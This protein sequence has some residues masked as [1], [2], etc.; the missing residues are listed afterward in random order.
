LATFARRVPHGVLIAMAGALLISMLTPLAALA[1]TDLVIGGTARIAYANGDPVAL[2]SAV[3]YDAEVLAWIPE[4][5]TVDVVDGPKAADDGALWYKV[6]ANGESG[7]IVSY[8]LA[9]GDGSSAPQ[10]TP[11]ESQ[12]SEPAPSDDAAAGAPGEITGIA[13]IAGTNN[14][15]VRCRS[16]ASTDGSV[17]TVLAEAT[18]VELIGDQTNGW[19]PVNCNGSAGFV[20]AEF[21]SASPP[22]EAPSGD[23]SD[24]SEAT[25][26]GGSEVTGSGTIYNTN[27][28]GIRCR[29]GASAEKNVIT[30]LTAG[31]KV[32]LRGTSATDWQPVFC[33]GRKGF[34]HKG[35]VQVGGSGPEDQ[36]SQ[37]SFSA[38]ATGTATVS[39]TNG[40]GVNCRASASYSGKVIGV[41]AEGTKVSLRGGVQG[42]WQPV[43]CKSRNGFVHKDYLRT[44]GASS[45]GS[46]SSGGSSSS[47]YT[48]VGTATVKTDD[49]SGLNCRAGAGFDKRIIT[50]LPN[51][52]KIDLRGRGNGD[53]TPVVCAGRKAYVVKM[54]VDFGG[55]TAG[56]NGSNSGNSGGS[57]SGLAAGDNAKV[58]G[59]NGT[60]VR[61]RSGASTT[62]S[63]ISVLVENTVVK[64]R[65]GS[66]GSWV[67]VTY[68]G[69]NGFVHK[70]YLAKT[71]QT[72]STPDGGSN[73]GNSGGGGGYRLANGDHAKVNSNLNLRYSPSFTGGV[74]AVAPA[75]T[76]VLITG[77]PK[78]G[79]YPVDWDGLKGYMYTDFLSKTSA[80]LSDRGGSGNN[81]SGNEDPPDTS[82]GGSTTIVNYAMQYLGYPYVWAT[83]GPGS[84]DCSGFTY[85]VIL[86]TVG[87]NIGAGLFTQVAAGTPVTRSSLQPGDLVFFQN[88]YTWGLS[89]VGIYIGN[90]QF[91]HAENAS[92]GVKISSLSSQY[93]SSRWYGAVRIR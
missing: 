51:G 66:T 9:L 6:R 44:G 32:D 76:V 13:Y 86:N 22:A 73:S 90:D 26:G 78:S 63:I 82:A 19:Q 84:F 38:A 3:G 47:G 15:G 81:N 52:S 34:I 93:Y 29:A 5:S 53:W 17:I 2:R 83:H 58:T 46:T 1:D 30:V 14:D 60:G 57:S 71:S 55:S 25:T 74:A 12:A 80:G 10:D 69:S 50:T 68:N 79:F 43:T 18:R 89:H 7:Y 65:S 64:V 54:Y 27:G 61:F 37:A 49:G 16:S 92:T 28:D 39:G 4:G 87:K 48:I 59:T 85:W 24:S 91:I 35:F 8:Y 42:E 72:A 88:T 62:A 75:G 21:V 40:G 41:L 56:N 33:A 36:A 20:A 67:A 70:D 77:T 11:E 23:S 31:Q 45:G